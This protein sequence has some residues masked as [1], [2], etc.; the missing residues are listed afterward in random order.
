MAQPLLDEQTLSRFHQKRFYPVEIGQVLNERYKIRAKLGCG[1]TSTVWLSRDQSTGDYIGLKVC[2]RDDFGTKPNELHILRHISTCS[3]DHSG[4]TIARQPKAIF[5]VDGHT[6]FA[7]NPCIC[8]LDQLREFLVDCSFSY[9]LV[10][11][12]I[13]H[14]LACTNWLQLDCGVVHTEI[15]PQ[16]ILL[17]GF[18]DSFFQKI[19][20]EE[21]DNP[22]IPIID[23]THPYPHPIYPSRGQLSSLQEAIGHVMLADFGSAR[24]LEA[25]AS[26]RG[27]WMPDTYRA[28]EILMT[29]PWGHSIDI[30]CIGVMV[31]E[32]LEGRNVFDPI[33]H[34][35]RQYVLPLALAQYIGLMDPPLLWMIE[36]SEDPLIKTFFDEQGQWIADLPIQERSFEDFV[37]CWPPG[38]DKDRLL[39]FIRKI[40]VWDPMDRANSSDLMQDEWVTARLKAMGIDLFSN[41]TQ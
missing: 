36:Q 19:E 34:V 28:P 21:I 15:T 17:Y 13:V 30:W 4:S 6:C 7:V 23:H 38:E 2:I 26:T 12:I 24:L 18:D 31:L 40:F 10:A 33:D 27:W 37:T 32:L 3:H 5:E 11:T 35:H 29:G 22:S 9:P 1:A 14:I 16:N 8:N 20:Q 41:P 25:S 39:N